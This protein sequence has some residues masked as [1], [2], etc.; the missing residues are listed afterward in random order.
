[1]KNQSIK[2]DIRVEG[3]IGGNIERKV[4][5]NGKSYAKFTIATVSGE[6]DQKLW[7]N[8]FANNMNEVEFIFDRCGY[9]QGDIVIVEG[10]LSSVTKAA[11]IKQDGMLL[12][13]DNGSFVAKQF[14]DMTISA[15]KIM[16]G[17]KKRSASES[18]ED[19]QPATAQPQQPAQSP[20]QTQQTQQVQQAAPQQV[21]PFNEI[22]KEIENGDVGDD[23]IPW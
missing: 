13:K 3:R 21:K 2:T 4:N 22:Q 14:F 11:V 20:Q 10:T 7:F 23:E 6:G 9:G 8:V 17:Q 12:T 18:I 19:H 1:M 16:R 15:T 5:S